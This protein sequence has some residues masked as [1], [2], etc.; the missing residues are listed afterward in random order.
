A[1]STFVSAVSGDLPGRGLL[2][3]ELLL[4]ELL[5]VC[6]HLLRQVELPV[7]VAGIGVV[8]VG[9]DRELLLRLPLQDAAAG[10]RIVA[11]RLDAL[12]E[13]LRFSVIAAG[14]LEQPGDDLVPVEEAVADHGE[15][16]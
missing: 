7:G 2:R 15:G 12:H 16:E 4:P 9:A 11:A 10:G 1:P 5:D 8:R 13:R 3:V 14:A 6:E